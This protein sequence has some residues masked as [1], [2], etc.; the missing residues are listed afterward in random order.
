M[1]QPNITAVSTAT[2]FMAALTVTM[3]QVSQLSQLSQL[4]QSQLS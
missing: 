4:S 3:L 2:N 1:L